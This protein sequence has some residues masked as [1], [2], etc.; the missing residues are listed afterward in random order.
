MY[1]Q[2][3]KYGAEII[4]PEL[5]LGLATKLLGRAEH[6]GEIRV[7]F[8]ADL[9]FYTLDDIK[10]SGSHDPIAAMLLCGADRA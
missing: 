4:T 6:L 7:G 2:R 3:L 9:A 1:L 8:Q 10:F 5:A